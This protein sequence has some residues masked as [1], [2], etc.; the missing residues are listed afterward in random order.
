MCQIIESHV[1]LLN[2]YKRLVHL[3]AVQSRNE[4]LRIE[5]G[6]E[7]IPERKNTIFHKSSR[8]STR[9]YETQW[10]KANDL[11]STQPNQEIDVKLDSMRTLEYLLG[12]EEASIRCEKP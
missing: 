8:G 9:V 3:I 1:K 12:A 11:I 6:H 10:S 4:D 2:E 5:H 7:W